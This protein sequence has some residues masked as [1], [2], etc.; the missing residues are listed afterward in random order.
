MTSIWR[1]GMPR[2]SNPFTFFLFTSKPHRKM[3]LIA[4]LCV[5]VGA[6]LNAF[7][8]YVY[9]LII[10][11]IAGIGGNSYDVVWFAVALFIGITL[12]QHIVWRMSGFAGMR[13]AT[14]VRATARDALNSYVTLHSQQYFSNRFAGSLANK[15]KQ[16][17]DSTKELVEMF[18]WSFLRFAVS[19]TA[20]FIIVFITSPQIGYILLALF[21][22]ITPLNIYLARKR[23]P[24]SI[25]TQDAETKLT[26][27]S[28]DMLTNITAVQEYARR[29]HEIEY[30]RSLITHRRITGIRNW[31]YSE[32][33]LVLNG[34]LQTIFIGGMTIFAVHLA[35]QGQI[36]PGDV[37]LF[38]AMIS[39]LE[40]QLTFIGSQF[41]S[42]AENWG[43]V[44][45]SL[46]IV[47]EPYQ[48]TDAEQAKEL[49]IA[50]GGI[51]FDN[52]TFEYEGMPVFA[53]LSLTIAP[54]ERVGL[55]G[56]SGAGKS[57][58]IKLILRHYD[59]A[60]GQIRI[61]GV[62][63]RTLK[64]ESLRSSIAVVPQDPALFHRSIHDNI[65][66][67]R[68]EA[69]REEVMRAATQAQAHDFIERLP[70]KYESMVGERGVKL[71]GG[72]RQ[73]IAI[74]RALLK[75]APILLLD[76]ATSALDS[77]SEVEVQKAL[78][79]LMENR[80]VLAIAHR[81]STLRAMDRLIIFDEGEV[82]EDGTHE[83]L[84]AKK[85]LYAELWA[86]QAGG[87]IED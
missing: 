58:L 76:E 84:L 73:R 37:I 21:L 38:L 44:K 17:G 59:L 19:L 75:D 26:G 63:I 49:S 9:K 71:S 54:G 10:D 5:V 81:L 22:I 33:I 78:L 83:E 39:L 48:V 29:R 27:A 6:S 61:D 45:E 56:R 74:A 34:I 15:I 53:G 24:L 8:P 23:V 14:G 35:I 66:Y 3:A 79:R 51:E 55:I 18:L 64:K 1:E 43:T 41:N 36:T 47:T 2:I 30:L 80:T 87:F 13:W 82:V 40:D 70:E 67:G 72:Q 60:G 42:L 86:H 46:S 31:S 52:V 32:W 85:G 16:A 20:S 28:V 11:A 62:D 68:P 69:T 50:N 57:T 65:A 12:I 4:A 77:E 25:A 7:T